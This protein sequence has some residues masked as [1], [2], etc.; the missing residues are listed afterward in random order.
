MKKSF[1]I[2]FV[3]KSYLFKQKAPCS[4]TPC[5]YGD[6]IDFGMGICSCRCPDNV[7]EIDCSKVKDPTIPDPIECKLVETNFLIKFN[8]NWEMF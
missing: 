6:L 4:N 7:G 3:V 2:Y 1:E 5:L 8:L